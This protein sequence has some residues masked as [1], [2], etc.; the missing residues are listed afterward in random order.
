M[1]PASGK[2]A[3]R[4]KR[5]QNLL[6][7]RFFA[8]AMTIR[9][10]EW[11]DPALARAFEAEETDAYRICTY[12]DGWVDRYG[13]DVLVSHKTDA[14]RERLTTELYLW[15]LNVGFKFTRVFARFL[16]K[17]N[18]ERESPRL[19]VGD[20]AASLQ[21][22]ALERGLKY[23]IDFAV[24]Y[25]V[26]LF[27]DQRH[28]RSRV[29][30]FRPKSLLN[31]FAYTCAFSVAGAHVGASTLSIDL[32]KKS[33]DRGR[34]NFELNDL[35]TEGHKFIAEDVMTFLPRL[36]R[37]GE[38]FD[39][40]I[41]DPPTFSRTHRGKAFQVE[42]DFETLLSHSL[43]LAERDSKILLSTNCTTLSERALEVMSRFCLKTSRRAGSLQ[44]EP[45]L[46]DFP[47]G[48]GARTVWLTLR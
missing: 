35:S 34:G 37:K 20:A 44:S 22:T 8:V 21:T 15:S 32:S 46:P 33:L 6:A 39:V 19:V 9:M 28:N 11:M 25:S 7:S 23:A 12:P 38:K 26:G 24:G 27:V 18:A 45:P 36:A 16:P 13:T 48:A 30:Q 2:N 41:L 40:I 3:A 43:E 47:R 42:R 14:A 17:Q 29:Q 4:A 5:T 1:L 31:C 10:S